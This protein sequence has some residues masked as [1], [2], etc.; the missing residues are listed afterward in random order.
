MNTLRRIKLAAI[1]VTISLS[2]VGCTTTIK[3]SEIP[4]FIQELEK[5]SFSPEEKE[6]IGE[7]LRYAN[8]LEAR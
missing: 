4:F 7:L 5:H 6:T 8:E 3:K 1:S 2:I